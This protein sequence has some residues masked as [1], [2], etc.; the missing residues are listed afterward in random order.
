MNSG[1]K[2]SYQGCADVTKV[3]VRAR[4]RSPGVVAWFNSLVSSGS[5]LNKI[6]P[7]FVLLDAQGSQDPVDK[8]RDAA[9][10][11]MADDRFAWI[12]DSY[13]CCTC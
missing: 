7:S 6:L 12:D 5:E 1:N 4:V 3:K 8:D 11:G 9:A 2:K 10:G 13:P